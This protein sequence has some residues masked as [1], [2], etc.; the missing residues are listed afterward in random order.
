MIVAEA[1][2]KAHGLPIE[3]VHF[4]EV[5]AI[6]SI[7][8]I[9]SVAVCV[10]NLGVDDIV[11]SELYEGSGHVHCQHGMMPVPVPATAN[12]VA[13]NHLPMKITDAQGE[14]V[15]P[16]GA[17]DCSCSSYARSFA[18]GLSV[19]EDRPWCRQEGFPEGKCFE[20]NAA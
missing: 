1:E 10:D 18:R 8:D 15:T 19:A 4:H 6:D 12:I 14:M 9:I 20:S 13:A 7:V 17:A 3:E 11:V 2:S 5:G 16:T